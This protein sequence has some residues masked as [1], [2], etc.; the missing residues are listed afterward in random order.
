LILDAPRTLVVP[1]ASVVQQVGSFLGGT[2][3]VGP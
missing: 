2:K 3:A 1:Q